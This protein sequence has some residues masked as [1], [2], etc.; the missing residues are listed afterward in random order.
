MLNHSL[1]APLWIDTQ[2]SLKKLVDLLQQQPRIAVDTESNSLH[3]YRE[4]VCLIQFS[5]PEIDAL[6]DPLAVPDLSALGEIFSNPGI[7]KVFHAADYD[8]YG[9][10][11]DFGFSYANFFDTMIAART[12]GYTAIGLDTLIQAKFEIALNKRYQKTDWAIRPLEPEQ[13]DY[14]RMDTHYLLALRDEMEKELRENGRWELAHEDFA[15]L[16]RPILYSGDPRERWERVNGHQELTPRECTILHELCLFRERLAEKLDRPLFKVVDDRVLLAVT[17][18]QPTQLDQLA[19]LGLSPKQLHRMGRGMLDAV[20][21]GKT[22]PLVH[23]TERERVPDAILNRLQRLKQ[24]RKQTAKE[25]L[26]ESDVIL[27]RQIMNTLAEEAPRT[28]DEFVGLMAD[29][30]WRL[31]Q[32][33]TEIAKALGI[34]MEIA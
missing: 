4:R 19:V 11:R 18:E 9:L 33:G 15:R 28:W 22:A 10:S 7:E 16:C 3:A 34:R 27:P 21:R 23:P 2:S 17:R 5:T 32:Y 25:L 12:L 30:P 14:A 20:Q 8:V 26:V 24:W 29:Y 6:V 13:I 1:P 31:S